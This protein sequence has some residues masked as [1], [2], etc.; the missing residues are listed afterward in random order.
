MRV[1]AGYLGGRQFASPSGHHTHPMSDKIRGGLF[2]V[3]GDIEKLSVLDAFG[4]SGALS[5]EAVSRGASRSTVI[6]SDK[7]AQ[8]VIRSNITELGLNEQVTLI[9]ANTSS[10]LRRHRNVRFDLILCDPPFDQL[11]YE[12]IERLERLLAESGTL[13]LSWPVSRELPRFKTISI[14]KHKLYGDAQLVFYKVAKI[15]TG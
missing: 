4:G 13:V 15:Q 9:H 5:L 2:A 3:L 1:I 7:E 12:T 8:T 11:Q 6:E 14:V 10:W